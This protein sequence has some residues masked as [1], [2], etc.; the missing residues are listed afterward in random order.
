MSLFLLI[1]LYL[2]IFIY[3]YVTNL[4]IFLILF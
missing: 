4:Y 3:Y 2:H 1:T